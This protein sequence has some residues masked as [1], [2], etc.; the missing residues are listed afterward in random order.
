MKLVVLE[1]PYAG[2]VER[3]IAFALD[4]LRDCLLRGEAPFASHLLYARG[5][6]NDQDLDERELGIA[7]GLEWGLLATKTVAYVNLGISEGMKRGVARATEEGRPVE[8]RELMPAQ[9]RGKW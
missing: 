2:D 4:C 9:K 5:A 1:T 7:A 6:L 8:Y 3:N